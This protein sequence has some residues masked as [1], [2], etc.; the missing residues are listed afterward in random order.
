MAVAESVELQSGSRTAAAERFRCNFRRGLIPLSSGLVGGGLG[1]T[2]A[3]AQ[4]SS[5]GHRL[6]KA[7]THPHTPPR[8]RT[9]APLCGAPED[10]DTGLLF[11]WKPICRFVQCMCLRLRLCQKPAAEGK[12]L[13]IGIACVIA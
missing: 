6:L 3:R 13:A 5:L 8:S 7:N 9:I 2:I 10:P 11:R 1:S 4:P 12:M